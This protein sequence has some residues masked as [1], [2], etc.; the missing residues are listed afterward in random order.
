LLDEEAGGVELCGRVFAG[1]RV[2][3]AASPRRSEEGVRKP[4][5]SRKKRSSEV[6]TVSME[7]LRL[8]GTSSFFE[9]QTFFGLRV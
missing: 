3:V 2:V 9:V 7:T 8:S 1:L 5:V 6:L 4:V